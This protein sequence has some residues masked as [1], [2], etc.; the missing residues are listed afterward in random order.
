MRET[1]MLPDGLYT[2]H[3]R[4]RYVREWRRFNKVLERVFP[5][6]TATS[7]DPGVRLECHGGHPLDLQPEVARK[8]VCLAK[9]SGQAL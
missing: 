4:R 9:F 3:S 5:G 7:F 2:T 1:F 8:I 6:Y